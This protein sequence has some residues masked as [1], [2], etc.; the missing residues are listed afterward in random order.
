MEIS[1]TGVKSLV[2]EVLV[3]EF[4]NVQGEAQRAASLACFLW[5][6]VAKFATQHPIDAKPTD[7]SEALEIHD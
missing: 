3:Q 4:P 6:S 2:F 5:N 7:M 1:S